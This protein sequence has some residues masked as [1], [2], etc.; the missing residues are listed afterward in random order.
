VSVVL[1]RTGT[2]AAGSLGPSSVGQHITSEWFSGSW[3]ISQGWGPS[4]YS[5][6]PE[7]HGYAHW[8][9]GVDVGMDCGT[10]IVLPA[11]LQG[12]A[13]WI[14][15]PGGYG[16]ALRIELDNYVTAGRAGRVGNRTQDV[17][18]GH[19]RQRLVSDGQRVTGGVHL[20]ISNN[21]GNST[22]CHLHFEVRPAGARYGTDVDPTALLTVKSSGFPDLNPADAI[23]AAEQ[24]LS[25][26]IT[27]G[28]SSAEDTLLGV[29]QAGLGATILLGGLVIVAFGLRGQ[30]GAQLGAAVR[31]TVGGVRR[32]RRAAEYSRERSTQGAIAR[33]VAEQQ[34][35][36]RETAAAAA[37]QRRNTVG[38]YRA[39]LIS[40]R[41]AQERL[42]E[43][44]A[45]TGRRATRRAYST[46]MKPGTYRK[47]R[48]TVEVVDPRLRARRSR[49]RVSHQ[50]DFDNLAAAAR[51]PDAGPTPIEPP[52]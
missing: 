19:L 34:R 24:Q 27:S 20:A 2:L 1:D 39:G 45:A 33:D 35:G 7:G 8:H 31:Q 3:E 16:T 41:L 18:L 25:A 51:R 40:R 38:A 6:E 4:S 21:T 28:I 12:T 17:W 48:G 50:R 37:G 14:D 22:G 36:A 13:R 49:I 11:S 32:G 5:G 23:A 43:P 10:T 46:G 30:S 47:G 26:G 29:G 42:G 44:I 15:N 9:A 52:F